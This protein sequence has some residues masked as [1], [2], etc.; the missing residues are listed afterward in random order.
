V[1]L[2]TN[3]AA[4]PKVVKGIRFTKPEHDIFKVGEKKLTEVV[5]YWR[6]KNGNKTTERGRY[7]YT[8]ESTAAWGSTV[9]WRFT[10]E[11]LKA[12]GGKEHQG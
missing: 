11:Y 10:P 8:Y 2:K 5:E 9:F 1:D 7:S 6:D 4:H 12:T 3:Y